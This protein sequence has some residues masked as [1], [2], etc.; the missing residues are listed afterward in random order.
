MTDNQQPNLA[1]KPLKEDENYLIY[2]NGDL[3]SKKVNRFLK[4]KVDNVGY[5]TYALALQ[6]RRSKSGKKLS[7]MVYAH[8]L[9]AEYFLENP[10]N[11]DIVHHK[12]GNRL[13]N[14]V[15]N[16][17][18]INVKEHNQHHNVNSSRKVTPKYFEKNLPGEQWKV[19]PLNNLYE[20]SSCGRVR[21]IKTNRLLKID[22]FQKYQ[23]VKLNDKKHYYLHRIVYCTFNNDFNLEGFVIDHIDNNPKNNKLDNLQKITQQENCL[24]QDRFND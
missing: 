13:N 12:D 20:V 16:L 19:F 2:S 15:E 9:V 5:K 21:N 11:Y 4:G 23:R 17:E 24:K 10:N 6:E 8:R 3:Y 1:F 7:K 14:N 22:D 18:W